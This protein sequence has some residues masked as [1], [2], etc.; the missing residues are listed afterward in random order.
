MPAQR[1]IT[2]EAVLKAAFEL[3]RKSGIEAVN[4]RSIARKLG[5]S[6]QPIYHAFCGM[7]ELKAALLD[8]CEERHSA[9]VQTYMQGSGYAPYLAYGLG[10]VSFAKKERELFRYL[11]LTCHGDM[12]RPYEAANLPEILPTLRTRYG[13]APETARALHSDM[14][15]Y[16]CGLALGMN[17]GVLDMTEEEIAAR[18]RT[19]F[20]AL[21][22]VYG[23][24]SIMI[25][26]N[27]NETDPE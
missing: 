7:D 23:Q 6:T 27:N 16:A 14:T 15:V 21:T 13:Y 25:G 8:A 20:T 10:F 2:R 9:E 1:K 17:A 26:E 22:S 5:C 19:E 12:R 11:F 4:A 3:L 18:F 24:P